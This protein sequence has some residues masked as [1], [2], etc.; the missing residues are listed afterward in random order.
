MSLKVISSNKR[1]MPWREG[2]GINKNGKIRFTNT[3]FFLARGA[4]A[5][6][7]CCIG[8]GC[9]CSKSEPFVDS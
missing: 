2:R 1:R 8:A 3:H 9:C 7:N 4:V 6:L 5:L